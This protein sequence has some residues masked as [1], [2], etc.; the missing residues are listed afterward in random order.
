VQRNR[1]QFLKTAGTIG[2]AA[3]LP[4]GTAL[5]DETEGVETVAEVVTDEAYP[6]GGLVTVQESLE[7]TG[8]TTPFAYAGHT[9]EQTGLGNQTTPAFEV[10]EGIFEETDLPGKRIRLEA[11]WDPVDAGP[12]NFETFFQRQN[13]AGEWNTIAYGVGESGPQGANRFEVTLVNGEEYVGIGPTQP[14]GEDPQTERS[15]IVVNG[16]E[17]YRHFVGGRNGIVD[18][19]V[20]A[21]FQ[22]F[23]PEAVDSEE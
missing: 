14:V 2:G 10:D 5:A 9:R 7:E 18:F 15:L 6:Y 20:T 8:V 21:T 1:R 4:V 12:A 11:T 17:T 23:D 13:I 16:G 22:A 19:E 3:V